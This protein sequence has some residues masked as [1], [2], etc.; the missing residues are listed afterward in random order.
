MMTSTKIQPLGATSLMR[1]STCDERI[2]SIVLEVSKHFNVTVLEGHR[3]QAAQD[4]AV[5]QGRSKTPWP[6]SKHNS[7]PSKAVDIAPYPID[8]SDTARFHL[9]AG[10]MLLVASQ[11]GVKL[12]YGGDFNRNGNLKDDAFKDLPHFE[13]DEV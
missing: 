4:L 11:Q 3:G 9:L 10:A 1:L 12:R 6:T 13:I 8:W 7:M 2:K 5:Q